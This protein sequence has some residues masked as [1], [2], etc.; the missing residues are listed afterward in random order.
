MFEPEVDALGSDGFARLFVVEGPPLKLDETID[1]RADGDQ[2][3]HQLD[4]KGPG[5][6]GPDAGAALQSLYLAFDAPVKQSLEFS[7]YQAISCP[8][9]SI[10]LYFNP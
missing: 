5:L 6:S 1:L 10:A 9:L 7:I 2:L 4:A 8:L 3:S